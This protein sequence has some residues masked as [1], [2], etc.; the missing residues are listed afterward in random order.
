M[1][2]CN[3]KGG[4]GNMLFQIAACKNF[5]ITK[6]TDCSFPNFLN[7][8]S[9]LN[10]EKTHNPALN[11]SFEYLNFL[12]L[13]S[14]QPLKEVK[15]YDFP[16]EY[17]DYIPQ[18]NSFYIDG[19]FQS[20]KYFVQNKEKIIQFLKPNENINNILLSK[21]KQIIESNSVSLHVRRGDYL[22]FPSHHPV[23]QND[24][25]MKSL[26]IVE[27]YDIIVVFSDD[28]QWCKNNLL[29]NKRTFYI[30]NE[31]D[32]IEL[33]LM[34]KCKNNIISNSSFSWWGAWLNENESKKVIAPKNWF[35]TNLNHLRADDIYGQNWILQ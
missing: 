14:F 3:L 29:F 34:T 20:E 11:Y 19:F 2:Y 24:Y 4:L 35:G 1:I 9:F 31:K 7:H 5:A 33:F 16:F 25:F 30:E 18:E 32:Y 23:Q 22:R 26:E 15:K 13:N 8:L 21:Y 6:N 28:I 17:T 27:K 12:K 10:Q